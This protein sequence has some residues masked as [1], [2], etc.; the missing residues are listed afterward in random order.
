MS[1]L[2]N[3]LYTALLEFVQR[4]G[5]PKAEYVTGFEDDIEH[6]GYCETCSY[7][8]IVVRIAFSENGVTKEFVYRSTFAELMQELTS[9]E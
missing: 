5:N 4:N 1:D 8:Y 3:S 2:K 6:G 7:E 9:A